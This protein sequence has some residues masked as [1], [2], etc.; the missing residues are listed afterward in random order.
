MSNSVL[1]GQGREI[2]KIPRAAWE[3]HLAQAPQHA[4]A[5]LSFMSEAHHLVRYYVVRELPVKGA[6]IPPE[7]IAQA[8]LLPLGQVKGILEKLER[9]LVF[10]V[11]DARGEVSWAFPVTV[12]PTPHRLSFSSG[13]RLY[14]A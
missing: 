14:G 6:P 1:L 2:R 12:D 4:Q 7:A 10:L 13:E 8:L 3:G 5:R 11:R 9:E